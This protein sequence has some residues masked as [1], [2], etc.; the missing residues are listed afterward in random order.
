MTI[1][2]LGGSGACS[3]DKSNDEILLLVRQPSMQGSNAPTG[4][5]ATSVEKQTA[6]VA[7]EESPTAIIYNEALRRGWL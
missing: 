4:V 6:K 2:V 7:W 1:A 5:T 3:G